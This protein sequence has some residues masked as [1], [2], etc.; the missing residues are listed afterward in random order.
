MRPCYIAAELKD[1]LQTVAEQRPGLILL[2]YSL[3][4]AAEFVQRVRAL[5]GSA[6]KIVLMTGHKNAAEKAGKIDADA[7]LLKPFS[8]DE[9]Y[10]PM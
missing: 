5:E 8:P 3:P 7:F 1:A 9:L 2:H 6:P 10:A 4:G